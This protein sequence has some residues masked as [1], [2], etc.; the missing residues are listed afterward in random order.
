[1]VIISHIIA[2]SILLFAAF[3][4]G[5]TVSGDQPSKPSQSQL[6]FTNDETKSSPAPAVTAK[7]SPPIVKGKKPY[8]TKLSSLDELKYFLQE[9]DRMAA[10]KF[11]APWCK[12]CQRLGLQFTRL[13]TELG[14]GIASR[15]MVEGQLRFAEVAYS[16]QTNHFVQDQLQVQAV[17]TLQL[18]HGFHKLWQRSGTKDTRD[19]RDTVLTLES[20]TN[21]ELLI[22]GEEQDD[23]ILQLAIED[24]M[25]DQPDFLNE[26]W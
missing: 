2:M 20:K 19:L 8:I 11:Y 3:S 16:P 17:P 24:T 14:D 26:E 13:A 25:F 1:M 4:E 5:F 22:L 15:K 10:I 18:Y 12:T 9:D 7:A 6:F 21:E 23:G